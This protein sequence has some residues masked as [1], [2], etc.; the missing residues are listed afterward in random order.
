MPPGDLS[1]HATYA[2]KLKKATE[3]SYTYGKAAYDVVKTP[4]TIEGP[5]PLGSPDAT[6]E[7]IRARLFE[8][9]TG[10][11]DLGSDWEDGTGLSAEKGHQI[12]TILEEITPG[13]LDKESDCI[14]GAGQFWE[15][16]ADGPEVQACEDRVAEIEQD[17]ELRLLSAAIKR[18][19]AAKE[20]HAQAVRAKY[21]FGDNEPTRCD[22]MLFGFFGSSFA[23]A[24]VCMSVRVV[25]IGILP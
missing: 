3:I 23:L 12:L 11:L 4:K 20:R 17:Q 19:E 8:D 13:K 9:V 25:P 24:H 21:G 1:P 2:L 22:Q 14:G 5:K 15:L 10:D 16:G 6:T 18:Y 7:S